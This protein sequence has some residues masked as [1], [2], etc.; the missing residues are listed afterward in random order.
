MMKNA[1]WLDFVHENAMN[2]SEKKKEIW[3]VETI[4]IRSLCLLLFH[5]LGSLN[6]SS[7][8]LFISIFLL[9][10]KV[11]DL[12]GCLCFW[13]PHNERRSMRLHSLI[14]GTLR[15]KCR[16]TTDRTMTVNNVLLFINFISIPNQS[17]ITIYIFY[18]Q[19]WCR[20]SRMNEKHRNRFHCSMFCSCPF[21][22]PLSVFLFFCLYLSV[23]SFK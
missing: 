16:T 22:I 12:T 10:W 14:L 20:S 3:I 6:I 2:H 21:F 19:T 15:G 18:I 4:N 9:F 13:H 1:Y 7:F 5:F 11:S 8:N 23:V 17:R